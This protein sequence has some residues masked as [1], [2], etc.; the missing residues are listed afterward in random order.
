MAFK[1]EVVHT[2]AQPQRHHMWPRCHTSSSKPFLRD[3]D[4]MTNKDVSFSIWHILSQRAACTVLGVGG[5][6]GRA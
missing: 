2:Q 3:D 5:G 1:A 6:P 4:L